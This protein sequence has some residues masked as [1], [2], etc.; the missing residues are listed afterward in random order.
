MRELSGVVRRERVRKS[1]DDGRIAAAGQRQAEPVHA[2][3]V[4]HRRGEHQQVV[5]DER[6]G[7]EPLER[8]SE[9]CQPDAKRGIGV[10]GNRRY[11]LPCLCL[12][13]PTAASVRTKSSARS[14]RAAWAKVYRARDR[15]LDRDVAIKVLPEHLAA[16]RDALQRFEREAKAVAAL[17]H[18]N[19]LAIHDFGSERGIAC[20]VTELLEGQTLRHVVGVPRAATPVRRDS[21]CSSAL[22]P[23]RRS[24]GR[25]SVRRRGLPA[26]ARHGCVCRLR[27]PR[28]TRLR[29][30]RRPVGRAVRSRA[31]DRDRPADTSRATDR[32]G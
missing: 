26:S 7:A 12:C 18:P 13:P 23:A 24:R 6:R 32:P 8:R 14:A 15:R 1:A 30:R 29:S 27:A 17:S 4:E 21:S 31:G 11:N 10:S 2:Q 25:T 22:S 9:P 5:G 28:S 16:D 19:I 3:A 20:A